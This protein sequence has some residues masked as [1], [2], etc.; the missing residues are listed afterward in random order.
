VGSSNLYYSAE[1]TVTSYTFDK[2]PTNGETIYVRLITN[3][4][5]TWVH[6]DYTYTAASEAAMTSPTAGS[7]FAGASVTFN[8]TTIPSATGYYLWIGSSGVGS[9]DIYYSAEKTVTSYT[10]TRMPTNGE[11]IYV[12][13]TTNFNGTWV[14]NDY[15]YRAE[16]PPA[17]LT[18][19]VPGSTL[20]GASVTF[21]WSAPSGATGYYL[22]IGSQGVGSN[23]IYNSAEKTV[24]TYTFTRVPTNGET[25][26]VRLTTNY[27]GTWVHNDY[28]YT[29]A[30]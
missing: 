18:A 23:D 13:L 9:S 20:G 14:Y 12:R 7:T 5:G 27:N 16:M 8:W 10:F 21:D 2:M 26:Y 6:A 25:I 28:T 24:T 17:V 22:W 19:P 4:N 30:E 29:A 3:F 11:T 15:T 1:K